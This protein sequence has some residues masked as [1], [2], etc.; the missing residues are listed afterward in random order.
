MT[1]KI[2]E[3]PNARVLIIKKPDSFA[4]FSPTN[5][6]IYVKDDNDTVVHSVVPPGNWQYF[7]DS[8]EISEDVWKRVVDNFPFTISGRLPA[9]SK[10]VIRFVNYLS[11]S[12]YNNSFDKATESGH[13]LLQANGVFKVNPYGEEPIGHFSDEKDNNLSGILE[14]AW[15]TA[16]SFT[17]T[18]ALIEFKTT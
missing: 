10:T 5:N 11:E 9:P 8:Y 3:T 7:G 13:S 15:Q 4:S 12:V 2:I 6:T 14:S 18:I 17:G 1:Y 16:E